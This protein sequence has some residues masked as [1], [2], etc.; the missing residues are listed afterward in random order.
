[1]S[2]IIALDPEYMPIL[3]TGGN[4]LSG[5]STVGPP[6]RELFGIIVGCLNRILN[7][8]SLKIKHKFILS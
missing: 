1:V 4:K 2:D 5:T 8:K 3:E 6:V 7:K